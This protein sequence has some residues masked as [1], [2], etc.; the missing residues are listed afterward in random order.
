MFQATRVAFLAFSVLKLKNIQ[1]G[2]Q[3]TSNVPKNA[4]KMLAFANGDCVAFDWPLRPLL[5]F[6]HF[7]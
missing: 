2:E 7:F 1:I 6:F 4:K 5:A 3:T